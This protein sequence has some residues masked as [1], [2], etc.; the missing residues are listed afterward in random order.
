MTASH[1][2]IESVSPD[3]RPSR[4]CERFSHAGISLELTV[5][6]S[7]DD[8]IDEHAFARD[9]RL[10]YWAHL[11][12]ASK[13]LSR[14]LVDHSPALPG[15][16]AEAEAEDR[17]IEL[18]CGMGLPSLVLSSLGMNVLATDWEPD[19]LASLRVNVQLIGLTNLPTM[20][21]DWRDADLGLQ[22]FDLAI[23][24]DLMY[25]QRNAIALAELLPRILKPQGEFI[26]ADPG[27]R[28]LPHFELLMK[29]RG[30]HQSELAQIEETQTLSTGPS[31][32]C[33]RIIKFEQTSP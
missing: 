4:R 27:R 16:G 25:E 19:A 7:A 14:W 32:S 22:P 23:G 9:E 21:L 11:W 1:N 10:P 30:W 24:A 31:T 29:Q 17:I 26:L 13:A 6:A 2:D 20:L 33:V 3:L 5:P 8:L 12:P 28:W 18:G 15:A